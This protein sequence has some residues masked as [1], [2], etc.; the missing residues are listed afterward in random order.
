MMRIPIR[1]FIRADLRLNNLLFAT[2]AGGLCRVSPR[3][4]RNQATRKLGPAKTTVSHSHTNRYKTRDTDHPR[5]SP[6]A[7]P[8]RQLRETV[9]LR[10]SEKESRLNLEL[11]V[12]T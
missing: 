5:P 3:R 9:A 2:L 6:A 1:V 8:A 4:S 12:C 7:N 10:F 11:N